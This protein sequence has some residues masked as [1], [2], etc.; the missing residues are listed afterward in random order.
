MTRPF[1]FSVQA[2]RADS[3]RAWRELARKAEDLGYSTLF[4]PDHL[5][6][7]LGPLV[8]LA[9]AAAVTESLRVGSLVFDNDYRH[10]VVLAKEAATLDLLSEGRLELGLGAGW[11]RSDYDASGIPFDAPG[12]RVDRMVEG[13][14]VMKALWSTGRCTFSGRHYEVRDAL[15]SP[16]PRT[17]PRP[18]LLI[19]GGGRRVLSIAAREADIVGFNTSLT[20]GYVG[21]EAAASALPER[22]HERVAW[23]RE[24]AGE[25]FAGLELQCHTFLCQVTPDRRD[26]AEHMAPMFGLAPE[27]A[28]DVP[29]LLVG[30]VEEICDDLLRRREAFGFSYWTIQGDAMESFAPVV[31]RLR[32]V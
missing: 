11:M 20:A 6:D 31:A 5:D 1:R 27:A 13:L 32:G 26:L 30:T 14:E 24:A 18:T 3:A 17:R 10:P 2:S 8:A 28:L 12:V 21:P 16:R 4:V 25:R 29:L 22:F 7:Q 23:V 9:T 15:G 19:G